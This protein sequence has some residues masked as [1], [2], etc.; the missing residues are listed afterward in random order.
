MRE[1]KQHKGVW[2]LNLFLEA[3]YGKNRCKEKSTCDEE[4]SRQEEILRLQ[5]RM[6]R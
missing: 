3:S 2:P 1:Q 6:I 5:V 4:S